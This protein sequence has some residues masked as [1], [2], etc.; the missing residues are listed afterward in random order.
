MEPASGQTGRSGRIQDAL[1]LEGR[2][3]RGIARRHGPV[4]F[5][6]RI[7]GAGAGGGRH[8]QSLPGRAALAIARSWGMGGIAG[9][10]AS[11][12]RDDC[13]AA[14]GG[15]AIVG[16]AAGDFVDSIRVLV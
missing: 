11:R 3:D 1:A 5:W 2:A 7:W 9:E 12:E 4:S 6:E 14:L 10:S 16:K 13:A 8:G 15:P